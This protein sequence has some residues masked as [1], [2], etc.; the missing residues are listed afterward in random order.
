MPPRVE[1]KS[2][3]NQITLTISKSAMSDVIRLKYRVQY[4]ERLNP[5]QVI[6]TMF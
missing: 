6:H 2:D 3:L 4:W 1:V 5:E